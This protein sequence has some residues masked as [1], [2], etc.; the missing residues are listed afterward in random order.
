LPMDIIVARVGKR[1]AVII[2]YLVFQVTRHGCS[3]AT[4]IP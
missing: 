4:G 1:N 3:R 2:E